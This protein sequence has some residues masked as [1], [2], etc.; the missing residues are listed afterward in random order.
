MKKGSDE[1]VGDTTIGYLITMACSNDYY[2]F[3]D[4]DGI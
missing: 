1:L 4:Y 3:S 2:G